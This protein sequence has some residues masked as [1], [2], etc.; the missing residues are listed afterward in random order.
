MD[1]CWIADPEVAANPSDIPHRGVHVFDMKLVLQTYGQAVQG[2]YG[3]SVGRKEL[4]KLFGSLDGL[5]EEYLMKTITLGV[6]SD[7]SPTR[8]IQR[9]SLSD[10][11]QRRSCKTLLSLPQRRACR[12]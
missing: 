5:F 7:D 8:R 10:E 2:A 3:P 6:I 11:Q 12:S 1:V 9:H 4:V